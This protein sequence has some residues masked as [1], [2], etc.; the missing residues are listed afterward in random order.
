[1]LRSLLELLLSYSACFY[2]SQSGKRSFSLF[3]LLTWV[4]LLNFTKNKTTNER[5]GKVR[6]SVATEFSQSA[7]EKPSLSGSIA[8]DF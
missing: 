7:S 8:E 6:A 1:M 3:S 4:H 2:S 5:F